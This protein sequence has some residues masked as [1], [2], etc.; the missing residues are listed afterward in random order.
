[1]TLFKKVVIISLIVQTI[2]ICS[3][4]FVEYKKNIV[5][6]VKNNLVIIQKDSEIVKNNK[7]PWWIFLNN[8]NIS[9]NISS[10]FFINSNTIIT[11]KHWTNWNQILY[12]INDFEWNKYDWDLINAYRYQDIALINTKN[13]KKDFIPYKISNNFS[14]W[15]KVYSYSILN[16]ESKKEWTIKEI[17]DWKIYSTIIFNQWES[18]SP[19][20]DKNS[21]I[22]WVNIEVDTEKKLWISINS[23]LLN[24][25]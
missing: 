21:Q 1:M 12:K 24:K 8:K 25:K 2:I 20:F 11:A 6:N 14:I 16:W 15:D 18:W 10:W 13:N 19:L 23:N 3:Y 7:N 17:K 9:E 22:I 5:E 4:I